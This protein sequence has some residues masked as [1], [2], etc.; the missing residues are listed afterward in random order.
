MNVRLSGTPSASRHP[1]VRH[2]ATDGLS[3][4]PAPHSANT[5]I[6]KGLDVRRPDAITNITL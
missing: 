4:P 5:D 1:V 3:A 2:T 6:Y